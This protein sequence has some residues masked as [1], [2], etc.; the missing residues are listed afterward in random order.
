MNVLGS[1][2]SFVTTSSYAILC[3]AGDILSLV[4]QAIGGGMASAADTSQGQKNG[5][6][7]MVAGI[8]IQVA[9]MTFY[10]I[11]LVAYIIRWWINKPFTRQVDLF[12]WWPNFMRMKRHRKNRQ[13]TR[14]PSPFIVPQQKG[15][16]FEQQSQD[17]RFSHRISNNPFSIFFTQKDFRNA[18]IE[19]AVCVL[20]T[21]LIYVRSIYRAIELIDGW[22][23]PV[24]SNQ[25]LFNGMDAALMVSFVAA[26]PTG[27]ISNI[28]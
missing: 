6:D 1:E 24:I 12:A 26:I 17:S 8:F 2:Y 19:L 22:T 18:K 23:G 4:I 27:H 13:L 15:Q 9:I 14:T 5:A 11:V 7:V 3:I 21:T 20:T 16:D 10:S 25:A 28:S